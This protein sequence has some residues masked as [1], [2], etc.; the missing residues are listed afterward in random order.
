M[1]WISYIYVLINIKS[2]SVSPRSLLEWNSETL[3]CSPDSIKFHILCTWSAA[4]IS[5]ALCFLLPKLVLWPYFLTR[6]CLSTSMRH[7]CF[8]CYFLTFPM[9]SLLWKLIETSHVCMSVYVSVLKYSL[10]FTVCAQ[11]WAVFS[12]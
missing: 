7:C 5:A 2:A 12:Q 11:L 1:W 4:N 6:F 8:S 10:Y 3:I 9:T